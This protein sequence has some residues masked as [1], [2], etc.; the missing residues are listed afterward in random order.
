MWTVSDVEVVT[1][2]TVPGRVRWSN[3]IS[4][5]VPSQDP[6]RE[7]RSCDLKNV[8][9]WRVSASVGG[10]GEV[11]TE[12]LSD[13]QQDSR[14]SSVQL[15]KKGAET[16]EEERSH[17]ETI[18]SEGE[19]QR[20]GGEQAVLLVVALSDVVGALVVAVRGT[21]AVILHHLLLT[22]RR[23]KSPIRLWKVEL[24]ALSS[25]TG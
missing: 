13:V 9:G 4:L 2:R 10:G 25:C 17:A 18:T 22:K 20:H 21:A 6:V 15:V 19:P 8:F 16:E 24:V 23:G 14:G 11:L 7:L 1:D 12:I 5:H 3:F